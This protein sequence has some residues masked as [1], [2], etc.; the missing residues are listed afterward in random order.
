MQTADKGQEE[1]D[2]SVIGRGGGGPQ[3]GHN[4]RMAGVL[5][6]Y[7]ASGDLTGKWARGRWEELRDFAVQKATGA[8]PLQHASVRW[9]GTWY[10]TRVREVSSTDGTQQFVAEWGSGWQRSWHAAHEVRLER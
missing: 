5:G 2:F 8:S 7:F 3:R 10:S 6:R 4:P 1:R 9:K